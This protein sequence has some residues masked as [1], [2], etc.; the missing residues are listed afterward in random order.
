VLL[1]NSPNNPTGAVYNKQQLSAI[2]QVLAK[3]PDIWVIAD[4]IYEKLIYDDNQHYSIA[5]FPTMYER[6]IV[7]N[8]MSKAYAMTGW[9]IGYCA[10]PTPKVAKLMDSLQSH[11]SS[12]ANSIAQYASQVALTTQTDFIV[13]MRGEFARRR[14]CMLEQLVKIN[15]IKAIHAQGAFY[16]MVD[17]SGLFDKQYKGTVIDSANTL[18]QLLISTVNVVVIPCEGFG[19]S[20]FVRLSY[21]TNIDNIV[22]GVD[23]LADFIAQVN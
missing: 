2:A 13:N 21:A 18:A 11:Q 17:V 1:L 23:R 6:T 5:T 19:A 14:D 15:G 10:A 9:R 22:V 7:I 16:I 3:Y 4:E 8:G 20:H 12:N